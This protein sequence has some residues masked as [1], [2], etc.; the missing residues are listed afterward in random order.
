MCVYCCI[1]S[2]LTCQ[3]IVF[4]H[5]HG[6]LS[7]N[8]P[9]GLLGRQ[10]VPSNLYL[11]HTSRDDDNHFIDYRSRHTYTEGNMHSNNVSI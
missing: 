10:R 3:S 1:P 6:T 7:Y 2:S 9:M 5:E 4:R 11:T 8:H